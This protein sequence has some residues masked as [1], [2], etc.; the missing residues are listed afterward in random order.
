[1]TDQ[2]N[3]PSPPMW[4][5]PIVDVETGAFEGTLFFEGE[6]IG[7]F[8]YPVERCADVPLVVVDATLTP[9]QL[10]ELAS[11]IEALGKEAR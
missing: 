1:M 9:K 6:Y 11:Y 8:I 5:A 10:R 7:H 3:P 2:A 4:L